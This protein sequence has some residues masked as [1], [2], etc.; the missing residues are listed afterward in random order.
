MQQ[1][2]L[3]DYGL[4]KEMLEEV[5]KYP[6]LHVGRILSQSKNIYRVVTQD[7]E[8]FAEISGK[9]R[10]HVESQ[11][12]YPAVGDF[13]MLD[14]SSGENGNAIIHHVLSRKSIFVRKASGKT[15]EEQVVA[16]NIDTIFICMSV[17]SDFNLRRL[18]R[19]LA[20]TWESG[21]TPVVLLT[22]IDLC[23]DIYAKMHAVNSIACGVDIL[24]VSIYDEESYDDI[25]PY[26]LNNKTVALLGSSG[27]GKSTLINHLLNEELL[28]TNGIRSDDKGRHTT[29]R[30]ELIRLPHGGLIMDTPGMRE[31]GMCDAESGLDQTFK[32]IEFYLGKCRFSDCT[33]TT[34]PGCAIYEAICN[35]ELSEK[36]WKAYHKLKTE[37]SYTTDKSSYLQQKKAKFKSIAK[38]QKSIQNR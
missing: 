22:K 19:Y 2:N 16:T 37:D 20:L 3:Q 25:R 36:R 32:D 26:L 6:T 15:S 1:I 12:D 18:E 24:G 33:H 21:A 14:R 38:Y 7:G 28:D 10:Y 29:T 5:Q 23:D 17:N 13:V 9:Y 4:M 35:G 27:V 30:R 8:L 31:L 34:E 11:K